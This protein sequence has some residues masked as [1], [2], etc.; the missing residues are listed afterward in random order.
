SIPDELGAGFL[1]MGVDCGLSDAARAQLA[2]TLAERAG[3]DESRLALY[4]IPY[5]RGEARVLALDKMA[6][7]GDAPADAALPERDGLVFVEQILGSARPAL[8]GDL[9]TIFSLQLSQAGVSLLE[10]AYK[11]GA[12]PVGIV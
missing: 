3:V 1:T 10:G 7:P 11:S 4:P 12:A 8:L 2:A 5:H 9:R 6:A